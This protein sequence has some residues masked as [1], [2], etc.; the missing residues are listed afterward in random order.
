MSIS[1]ATLLTQTEAAYSALLVAIADVNVQ[2]Y[3]TADGRKVIRAD[4]PK[5]LDALRVARDQ[6]KR[7]AAAEAGGRSRFSLV[8]L[9]RPRGSR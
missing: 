8:S 2:E 5:T 7:E 6:L 9:R 1:A 3:W 4:F